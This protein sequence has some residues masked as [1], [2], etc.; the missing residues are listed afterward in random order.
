MAR[1][2]NI[3]QS[4]TISSLPGT[5][6]GFTVA[7]FTGT[8]TIK[9][10]DGTEGGVQATSTLTSTNPYVPGFH[11]T[12]TLTSTGASVAA[13][14]ATGT[15]TSGGTNFKDAVKASLVL[16][17][18]GTNP[19]AGG[20]VTV[21]GRVFTFRAA[22]AMND[23]TDVLIGSTAAGTTANLCKAINQVASVTADLTT[24]LTITVTAKVAGTAGN[25]IAVDEDA[26]HTSWAGGATALAGGLAAETV[27][28]G[29]T[30]YTF[31]N[32]CTAAYD[33]EIG[34][35]LTLS[36]R[37]LK[38]AINKE[39]P[40]IGYNV[41][42]PAHTQVVAYSSDATTLVVYGN[43]V[44]ASLNTVAT[45]ETCADA[46]WGGATLVDGVA[47]TA[48]TVT[49]GANVYTQ[50]DILSETL[51]A[52]AV[53]NQVL[54]GA[55]E[56][57]FLAALKAAINGVVASEGTLFSTGTV[58]HPYIVATTLAA[59]SVIVRAR[60]VGNAA[61]TAI[62]NA[63]GTTETLGDNY[64]WTAINMG[65]GTGA[66]DPSVTTDAATFTIGTRTYKFVAE[67][68]ETLS[69][70]S[71]ATPPASQITAGAVTSV[72][73]ILAGANVTASWVAAK[74]AINASGI[75][76]TDYSTGTT[77]NTDVLAGAVDATT[78]VITA[79]DAG[80]YGNSIATTETMANT[81]WTSTVMASGTGTRS[82]PI[83]GTITLPAV[84]VGPLV[85][86]FAEPL[87]LK[88]GLYATLGG[89]TID[90]TIEYN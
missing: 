31:K 61:Y 40:S 83:L 17:I 51:G 25:S 65:A 18:D 1:Y 38:N 3:T 87:S 86:N 58:K 82:T 34:S 44:G 33:V 22:A 64:A 36:L 75:A 47:T 46:A 9:L 62:V 2:K 68:D 45:T 53:A 14:H 11:A 10:W 26:D 67:L 15:L 19:T 13:T 60:Y 52:P 80:T 56:E 6:N 24:S 35:T 55:S 81:S 84:T 79:Y 77:Q 66:S 43:V 57:T 39:V 69:G 32:V 41:S 89:T 42:T 74:K 70:D 29:T 7:T 48:S 50:V 88:R 28:I 4:G 72:D 85:Y 49:I 27:T 54:R 23:A 37:N 90:V 21:D 20:T 71:T 16:T 73:Q 63:L 59:D 12:N 78:L 8:G 5:V 30:T 76:G